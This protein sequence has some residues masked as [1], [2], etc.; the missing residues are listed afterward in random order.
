MPYLLWRTRIGERDFIVIFYSHFSFSLYPPFYQ[1]SQSIGSIPVPLPSKNTT[2]PFFEKSTPPTKKPIFFHRTD[3]DISKVLWR[4]FF[5]ISIGSVRAA[6][7]KITR[8]SARLFCWVFFSAIMPSSSI[9]FAGLIASNIIPF[10]G[11]KAAVQ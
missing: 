1:T 8:V 3:L 6:G 9:F 10:G 11:I 7:S 5:T 2:T 4:C